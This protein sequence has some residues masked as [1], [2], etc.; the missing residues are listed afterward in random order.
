MPV[1][2]VDYL[3]KGIYFIANKTGLKVIETNEEDIE[4]N[5]KDKKINYLI[6]SQGF[7]NAYDSCPIKIV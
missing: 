1:L 5:I 4:K 2:N 7:K 6:K 3:T